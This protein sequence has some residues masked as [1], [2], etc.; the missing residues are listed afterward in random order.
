[1]NDSERRLEYNIIAIWHAAFLDVGSAE[2][3]VGPINLTEQYLNLSICVYIGFEMRFA[4]QT[5]LQMNLN[6][7]AMFPFDLLT[8]CI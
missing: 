8:V 2:K 4:A 3:T 1:M 7:D 6:I 5:I